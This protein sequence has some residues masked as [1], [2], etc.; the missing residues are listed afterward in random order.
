MD[1]YQFVIAIAWV[2][3]GLVALGVATYLVLSG[4]LKW[5]QYDSFLGKIGLDVSASLGIKD[6][7][8]EEILAFESF[9]YRDLQNID[10]G[11]RLAYVS[12][13]IEKDLLSAHFEDN[14][15]L[16]ELTE[17]GLKVH[18]KIIEECEKRLMITSK[19]EIKWKRGEKKSI[20]TMEEKLVSRMNIH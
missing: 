15:M 14:A 19:T 13:F 11:A 3:L 18:D 6:L 8:A 4:R 1:T 16:I 12:L 9:V 7:N 2:V 17:K 5:L 20:K 10:R